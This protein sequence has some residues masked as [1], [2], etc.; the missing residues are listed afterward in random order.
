MLDFLSNQCGPRFCDGRSRRSFL[1]VGGLAMGGLSL[2][3]ILAA[4]KAVP[5]TAKSGGLGHKA[6]I[7]IY[8]PGGPAH[9]DMYDLKM[10][11]SREIRGEFKPIKTRVPGIEI[12]ELLPRLAHNMD[13]LIPIRSI[14]GAKDRHESFQCL[15]GRLNERQPTGGWPEMGSSLSEL[16]GS[17]V[18]GI[19]PFVAL[20]P[21]MQH[22]PYN[23]IGRAHV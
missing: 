7:M 19:P 6:V 16:H 2:P 15:T 17:T 5:K 1:Q 21:R 9:Q 18:P 12:C 8:M 23:K 4:E 13:K 20:S 10:E 11:A 3:Q 14:V 22:R